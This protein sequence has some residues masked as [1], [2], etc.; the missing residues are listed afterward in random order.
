ML[1][2]KGGCGVRDP[3]AVAGGHGG[4]PGG[5]LIQRAI[6]LRSSRGWHSST[7]WHRLMTHVPFLR[8]APENKLLSITLT[9]TN[10]RTSGAM[11]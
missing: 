11:I 2:W 8:A 1:G 9:V 5:Q 6:P 10:D 4:V 3:S 7:Y